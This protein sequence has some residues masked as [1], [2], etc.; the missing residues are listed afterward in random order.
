[1]TKIK[2]STRNIVLSKDKWVAEVLNCSFKNAIS[3][4]D[5][6]G[7]TFLLSSSDHTDV[8]VQKSIMKYKMHRSIISIK[9][10]AS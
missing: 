5:I 9:E 7:N 3:S 10:S 4:L 6:F 1:M 2:L 8:P